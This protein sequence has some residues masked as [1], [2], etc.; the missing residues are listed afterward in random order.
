MILSINP[1][2]FCNFSCDFCYLTKEQLKDQAKIEISKLD[3]L[4]GQVPDIE[5]VDLYGG[6]IGALNKEYYKGLKATIRKYY[7]GPINIVTNFS[8]LN[9]EFFKEDII[10]TISY[11]FEAREESAKVFNN[12]LMSEK[13]FSI[14]ILA[15]E[16]VLSMEVDS[17]I[18]Q[19]NLLG[20]LVSVEIKPYSI[21]QANAQKITH[22]EYEDFIVKWVDSQVPKRFQF[23]NWD[24]ID[25]ALE[26]EYNAFSDNHVYITPSGN[27]AV[28]EFDKEDKEYFLELGSFEAYNIWARKE[29][30]QLSRICIEC[31]YL[32]HCLT[33]HYRYVKDLTHSC[34]GYKGLL[35]YYA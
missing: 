8:K 16:Q 25:A 19:L 30:T 28:L 1:S 5:Y 35:D 21:N 4:L 17:M 31:P 3:E 2:Y 12:M 24:N 15:T 18:N 7:S 27:F 29:K 10:L 33:E 22:K 32:G 23:I 20:N 13:D 34:S 9:N 14:L 6:E 11:D 26:L